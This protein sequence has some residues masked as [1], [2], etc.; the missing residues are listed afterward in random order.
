MESLV[1]TKYQIVIPQ[2]ARK[3]FNVRPG[4]KLNVYVTDDKIILSPKRLWPQ[5]YI[6]NLAGLLKIGDVDKFLETERSSWD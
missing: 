5:D 1:S 3:R 2:K 4:Q 6:K